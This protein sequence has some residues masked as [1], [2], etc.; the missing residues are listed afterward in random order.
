MIHRLNTSQHSA[1]RLRIPIASIFVLAMAYPDTPDGYGPPPGYPGNGDAPGTNS[2]YNG[3]TMRLLTPTPPGD[4]DVNSLLQDVESSLSKGRPRT[5]PVK[6]RF[7]S[8][9]ESQQDTTMNPYTLPLRP[10][11]P[12]PSYHPSISSRPV[13]RDPSILDNAYIQ[14]LNHAC[15]LSGR[16][17]YSLAL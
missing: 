2:Q 1:T 10:T 14:T 4:L 9:D 11:S 5:K 7:K 6:V 17:L 15:V 12:A 8:K 3:S 16:P 13:S